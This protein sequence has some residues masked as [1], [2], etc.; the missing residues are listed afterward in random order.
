MEQRSLCSYRLLVENIRRNFYR[1][2]KDGSSSKMSVITPN[3]TWRRKIKSQNVN[4]LN[5]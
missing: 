2:E 4:F 5:R 1:E 3:T